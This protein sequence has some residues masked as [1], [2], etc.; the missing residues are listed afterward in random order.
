M[1]INNIF[2]FIKYFDIAKNLIIFVFHKIY[3]TSSYDH[4]IVEMSKPY[5]A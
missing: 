1:I 4:T 3:H 2:Q 5:V